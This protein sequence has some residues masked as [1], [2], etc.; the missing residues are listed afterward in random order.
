MSAKQI[1]ERVLGVLS[2]WEY[3]A[4]FSPT[5][6]LGLEAA[7]YRTEAEEAIL[8]TVAEQTDAAIRVNGGSSEADLDSWRRKAKLTGVP[9]VH[10]SV[11][12]IQA[13]IALVSEYANRKSGGVAIVGGTETE[14]SFISGATPW[15]QDRDGEDSNDYDTTQRGRSPER[16]YY[17]TDSSFRAVEENDV[18]GFPMENVDG[19]P[20]DDVDGEPMDSI[21]GVPLDDIDGVPL[22]DIDGVPMDDID[23][24]PLDAETLH[25]RD[26][27]SGYSSSS[28]S[29]C[30]GPRRISTDD[31]LARGVRERGIEEHTRD[32]ADRRALL[33]ATEE[34]LVLYRDSLELRSEIDKKEGR[35]GLSA[36]EID[37][38]VDLERRK[39][40]KNLDISDKETVTLKSSQPASKQSEKR[41]R[42][43]R[44]SSSSSSS[45]TSSDDRRNKRKRASN[46]SRSSGSSSSSS[47]AGVRRTT[48]R[49]SPDAGER[50]RRRRRQDVSSS[51][52]SESS[53]DRRRHSRDAPNKSRAHPRQ[54]ERESKRENTTQQKKRRSHSHSTSS[55]SSSRSTSS[56]N[57]RDGRNRRREV[58]EDRK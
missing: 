48:K 35:A 46:N 43:V 56:L 27:A 37:K 21:D 39:L 11:G 18:D 49:E 38:L 55:S 30:E 17:S 32:D 3:W 6:L 12:E 36:S 28:S 24:V 33:R 23:G 52:E 34:K 14:K 26:N 47:D 54:N 41:G 20:L 15:T 25:Q 4:V 51:S 45:S 44:D 19:V 31:P 57:R 40:T 29:S 7:F 5:F 42:R 9:H 22:D 10:T 13:K 2:V 53:E 50:G 16:M 58:H 8:R 1:E